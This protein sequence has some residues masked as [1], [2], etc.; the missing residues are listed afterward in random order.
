MVLSN[1]YGQETLQKAEEIF[2]KENNDLY[3]S[4]KGLLTSG[5]WNKNSPTSKLSFHDQLVMTDFK[6]VKPL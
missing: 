5:R 4:F 6:F 3:I 1:L 2:G